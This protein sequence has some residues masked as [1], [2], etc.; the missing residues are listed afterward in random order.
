MTHTTKGIALISLATGMVVPSVAGGG[1]IGAASVV[2][3]MVA[4]AEAFLTSLTPEQREK[5]VFAFDDRETDAG[6]A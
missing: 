1:D 2:R 3:Q 5:A 6:A 4:G